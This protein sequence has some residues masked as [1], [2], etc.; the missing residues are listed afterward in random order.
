MFI[1]NYFLLAN[2]AR[3]KNK[4]TPSK[5]S[6]HAFHTFRRQYPCLVRTNGRTCKVMSEIKVSS[7]TLFPLLPPSS[8][9]LL[10]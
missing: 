10:S 7:N 3:G 6:C 1:N 9:P 8:M 5:P 4:K 2:A